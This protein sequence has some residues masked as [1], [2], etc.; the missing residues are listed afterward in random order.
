MSPRALCPPGGAGAPRREP[1]RAQRG[2]SLSPRRHGAGRWSLSRSV[3]PYRHLSRRIAPCRRPA[4]PLVTGSASRA[5]APARAAEGRLPPHPALRAPRL[6]AA[7]CHSAP[8]LF[9]EVLTGHW[10]GGGVTCFARGSQVGARCWRSGGRRFES[11]P[12]LGARLRRPPGPQVT[13]WQAG[14]ALGCDG[15][16]VMAF[17]PDTVV[18]LRLCGLVR[19][20]VRGILVA[21]GGCRS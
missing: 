6:A 13:A 15:L 20:G 21:T 16:V 4:P 11:C 19:H 14:V 12:R 7:A 3:A 9:T 1:G 2:S 8:G 18:F 10:G 17:Q 5:P